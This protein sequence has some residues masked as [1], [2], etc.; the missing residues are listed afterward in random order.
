MTQPG[1]R[2]FRLTLLGAV[3]VLSLALGGCANDDVWQKNVGT[4]NDACIE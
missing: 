4:R 2:A 3:A 1:S